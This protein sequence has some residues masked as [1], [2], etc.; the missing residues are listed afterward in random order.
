[1]I[2][3]GFVSGPLSKPQ[4][5]L[6]RL[7]SKKKSMIGLLQLKQLQVLPRRS[8]FYLCCTGLFVGDAKTAGWI[9]TTF[10]QMRKMGQESL[11]NFE[12]NLGM[13]FFPLG[14]AEVLQQFPLFNFKWQ[15][16]KPHLLIC[17]CSHF[18]DTSKFQ[19]SRPS[20]FKRQLFLSVIYERKL[21]VCA[22]RSH[23]SRP[24]T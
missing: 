13:F 1:M 22:C 19:T 14:I 18:T 9:S 4:S 17:K 24:S 11:F 10:G 21:N 5:S 20:C 15:K 16:K 3:V 2:N 8:Q 23:S 7:K 6:R 12:I